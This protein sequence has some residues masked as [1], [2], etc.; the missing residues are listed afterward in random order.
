MSKNNRIIQNNGVETYH[1]KT[2]NVQNNGMEACLTTWLTMK[3]LND[4]EGME[5]GLAL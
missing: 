1:S 4:I 5:T 3:A 2:N